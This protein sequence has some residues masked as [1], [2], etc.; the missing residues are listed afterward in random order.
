MDGITSRVY[1]IHA[2]FKTN[3][4]LNDI[5]LENGTILNEIKESTHCLELKK[6]IYGLVQAARQW[7]KKFKQVIL[8]M[9]YMASLADPCLFYINGKTKSFIIIYVDDGGIFS[10]EQTIQEVISALSKTFTVKYLGKL[11]NFIG[12]KLIENKD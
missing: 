6:A 11:E 12:C 2:R 5:S 9:G 7:W 1:K 10:D 8:D 4:K 3:G